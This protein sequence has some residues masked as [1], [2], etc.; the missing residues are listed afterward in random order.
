MF[1]KVYAI[2]LYQYPTSKEEAEEDRQ[3]LEKLVTSAGY[4]MAGSEAYQLREIH[5]RTCIGPGKLEQLKEVVEENNIDLIILDFPIKPYA[6]KYVE[7]FFNVE[8]ADR[9]RLILEIFKK[10]AT[11]AEGKLQVELAEAKYE[12]GRL[13]GKGL[14]K[15]LSRLGGGIG[16]RGPG[17]QHMEKLK[18]AYARKMKTLKDKLKSVE[19]TRHQ[20]YHERKEQGF[21]QIA[22]VGYT[23]AGKSS[24]LNTLSG[25]SVQAKNEL[26]TTVDPTTRK[27]HINNQDI[28]ITDTVGFIKKLPTQLVEGFESTLEQVTLSDLILV[29]IDRTDENYTEKEERVFEVLRKL[30]N[31]TPILKVYN[32]I[33]TLE[34]PY[35]RDPEAIYISCKQKTNIDTLKEKMSN[36]LAS[37][38]PQI[39]PVP[40]AD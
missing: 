36:F 12:L 8:V 29:V 32:K 4:F 20:H 16:T 17:E 5:P 34:E 15:Q 11:S 2:E 7:D 10:R 40:I 38:Y 21:P 3:E 27:I 22:L 1:R 14:G 19:K 23:N 39:K 6:L 18:R 31:T 13:V 30:H 37:K 28:L 26:F 25:S 33:D 24:L 35:K 9:T